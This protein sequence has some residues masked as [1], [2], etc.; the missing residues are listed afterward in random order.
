MSD[1]Y[2][3]LKS[4][5]DKCIAEVDVDNDNELSVAKVV[6]Y[7]RRLK[8]KKTKEEQKKAEEEAKKKVEAEELAKKRVSGDSTVLTVY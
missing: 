3:Y 8:E 5:S 7:W 6:E 4:W 2:D 1:T